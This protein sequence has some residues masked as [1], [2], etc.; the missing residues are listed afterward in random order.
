MSFV[1]TAL[2]DTYSISPMRT[3]F[4]KWQCRVR[5]ISMRENGG[6][7]DEGMMPEVY[8]GDD[9]ASIGQI[10]TLINKLPDYSVTAEL[11]FMA[12]K[13]N[14]PAQRRENAQKFFSAIFYQKA[15]EFSDILTATFQPGS[16][17][18]KRLR[19]AGLIRLVFDAYGQMFDL[20]CKV[21]TLSAS[22]YL[23]QATMA[24]NKLFNP[25]QLPNTEVLG[26]EPD[27]SASHS[28]PE[29]C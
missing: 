20:T 28:Q 8:L 3:A 29:F 11:K 1:S 10:I 24:H 14:D 17:G 26:F 15:A 18:A 4:L 16:A 25:S 7:P 19:D 6:Q 13:T 9:R 2:G 22:D 5:Q 23:H 27:W 21:I 12:A